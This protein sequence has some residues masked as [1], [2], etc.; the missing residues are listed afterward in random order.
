MKKHIWFIAICIIA[1]VAGYS[2]NSK[3]ISDTGFRVAVVDVQS[4]IQKSSQVNTLKADQQKKLD[5][6]K[7]TVDKARQDI[8]KETDP[9][10]IA[11]IEEKYRNNI[12]NQKQALDNEYN[13]KL[14]QIDSNIKAIVV[15]KA[16]NMNYNLVLPKNIVLFGGDD[17]TS[18][19][20]KSI[21]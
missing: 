13:S 14:K 12:N 1:F 20:A 18:E 21:K 9:A 4:L 17:I 15:E 10:K 7:A 11:Q 6:M 8:S 5:N 3:A 16:K 19:V 2:I